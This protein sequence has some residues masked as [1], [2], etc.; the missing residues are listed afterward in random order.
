[1]I[2]RST[3]FS[4]SRIHK[5]TPVSSSDS[6]RTTSTICAQ[7]KKFGGSGGKRENKEKSRHS[8]RS[9]PAGNC[10]H[11]TEAKEAMDNSE[12]STTN[13]QYSIPHKHNQSKII[14]NNRVQA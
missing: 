13:V 14:P 3:I 8:Q 10:Q 7:L 11:E 9:P 4:H 2:I 6:H 1:M 12:D 5:A